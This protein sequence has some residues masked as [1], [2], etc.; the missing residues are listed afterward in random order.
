MVVGGCGEWWWVMSGW[1][2]WVVV[3]PI[4]TMEV[5]GPYLVSMEVHEICNMCKTNQLD[6]LG[7]W[8]SWMDQLDGPTGRTS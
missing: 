1:W 3:T 4:S 2:W 5:I 6:G 7:T 8:I